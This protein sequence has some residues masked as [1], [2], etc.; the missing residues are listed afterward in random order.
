MASKLGDSHRSLPFR[1]DNLL[2]WVTELKE[3]L[4]ILLLVITNDTTQECPN[5]KDAQNK[6]GG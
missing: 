3:L 2:E 1:F 6:V 5:E 4:Y